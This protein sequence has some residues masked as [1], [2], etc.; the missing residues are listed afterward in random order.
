MD[1]KRT[2]GMAPAIKNNA[3]KAPQQKEEAA[4][5]NQAAE[6]TESFTYSGTRQAA[7]MGANVVGSF[8]V[9]SGNPYAKAAGF[10][11]GAVTTASGALQ[12][13]K[14]ENWRVRINGGMQALTGVATVASGPMGAGIIGTLTTSALALGGGH[15]LNQPAGTI[16]GIGREYGGMIAELGGESYKGVKNAIFGNG[17]EQA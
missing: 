13:A 14:G 16:K 8:L 4:Q 2:S 1:I 10:A 7:V 17:Q 5:D 11:I 6:P 12:A 3:A 9:Q 15:V